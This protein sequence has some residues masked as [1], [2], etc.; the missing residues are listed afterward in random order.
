[1]SRVTDSSLLLTKKVERIFVKIILFILHLLAASS[2][3]YGQSY[4]RTPEVSI[5][6]DREN[7]F[8][9]YVQKFVAQNRQRDTTLKIIPVVIH[10][11]YRNKIDSMEISM[12]RIQSQM[13]ATNSEL[14]RLNADTVKTRLQFK[15]VAADCNFKISLA[16]KKTDGTVFQGV[17]YHYIPNYQPSDYPAMTAK[18][19]FDPTRYLNV[20]VL[21]GIEGGGAVFPWNKTV[22]DDGFWVGAMAFGTIGKN[23]SHYMNEGT[24]FTHE[25]A[26][27]LGVYHTFHNST[28]YLGRCDLV[29]DGNIADRCCDTPLD[30][31]HPFS[32]E[33]CDMGERFCEG[34]HDSSMIA[35][36]EN[37]MFYNE[38][39]CTNMFSKDQRNR[40]RA[41]V[42]E[43]RA[44]LVSAENLKRTGV[45]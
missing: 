9:N 11:V 36:T 21:P 44:E 2:L 45:K 41:C 5:Y 29:Y 40:M 1:M 33:Q 14:R 31:S 35:Q 20:W 19:T 39:A 18:T 4:C 42:S 7:A 25:L 24:T 28:I 8:N 38:D 34:E 23:L 30:W 13:E 32:T 26:H 17:V 6:A 12:R 27:Y 43:L 16:G 37:F 22:I 15:P 10:V 3:V